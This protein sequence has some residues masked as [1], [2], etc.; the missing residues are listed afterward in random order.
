MKTTRDA[1]LS[2]KTE[3]AN[4]RRFTLIE[5]LVV[6]AIIAILAAILMP[7]LSSA[8]ERGR[9]ST[10]TNNLKQIG[11]A[12]SNY[13]QDFEDYIIPSNP[14]FAPSGVSGYGVTMWVQ[15]LVLR[16][17]LSS[18]NFAIP[19]KQYYTGV[20]QPAGVFRCPSTSGEIF[21][22]TPT[23]SPPANAASTTCYG[24]G[25]F[26]GRYCSDSY[27][28]EIDAKKINQY[29][30]PSKVMYAGE[31]EWGPR[32]CYAVSPFYTVGQGYILDGMFHH[33]GKANY[34]FFDFHVE[35]RQH[36]QV[37]APVDGTYFSAN[38]NSTTSNRSAFWGRLNQMQ[39][40]PGNY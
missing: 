7:A 22:D 1:F 24:L 34:L 27:N 5:L 14:S 15:M 30:I 37:P 12:L 33:G 21:K 17:Y 9:L 19:L 32:K 26:I 4:L 6:I 11:L 31:K 16:K 13:A 35:T 2:V 23:Q 3:Q 29:R 10:C 39:F 36:N 40:W 25:N 28:R 8:R 20:S 38:C 18:K